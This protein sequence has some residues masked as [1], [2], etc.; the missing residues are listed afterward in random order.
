[1]LQVKQNAT[2][3]LVRDAMVDDGGHDLVERG[4]NV[5]EGLHAGEA[6][7]EDVGATDDAGG[8]LLTL[9]IAL[10]VV[11]ELLAE[12]CRGTAKDTI[13]FAMATSR[14]GHQSLQAGQA[15]REERTAGSD[16]STGTGSQRKGSVAS[17]ESTWGMYF[18]NQC[19]MGSPLRTRKHRE[20]ER[21]A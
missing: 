1:L 2:G 3:A 16:V 6:G 11:T 4:F 17:Y 12:E 19:G 8:M 20:M 5:V 7:A 13:V 18:G 15:D 9:V 10:V 21:L 14:A